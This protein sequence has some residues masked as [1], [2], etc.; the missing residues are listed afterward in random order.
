MAEGECWTQRATMKTASGLTITIE[1]SPEEIQDV[2]RR[3][4]P[5]SAKTDRRG[6]QGTKGDKS[7]EKA[8]GGYVLELREGGFFKK[9]RGVADIR[10]G[11]RAQRHIIS[12]SNS[13]GVM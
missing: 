7:S 3:L 1:G 12:I 11:F 6:G 9:P 10:G 2:V 4:E 5:E 8:N 13:S